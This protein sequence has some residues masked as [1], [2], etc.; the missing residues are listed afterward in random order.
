ML[1]PGSAVPDVSV[2]TAPREE[3]RPL[4]EVLGDGLTLLCF[5]V[6]DWSPT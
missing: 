5:Y 6:Y 2:W 4:R 1:E 3:A